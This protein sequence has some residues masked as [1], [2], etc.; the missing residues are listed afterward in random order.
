VRDLRRRVAADSDGGWLRP[1]VGAARGD[2]NTVV[3][4]EGALGQDK[5]K[6]T[7]FADRELDAIDRL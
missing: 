1:G 3:G 2:D 6:A 4:L 5:S 7:G